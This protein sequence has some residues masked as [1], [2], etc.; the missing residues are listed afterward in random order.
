MFQ[1]HLVDVEQPGVAGTFN[2]H[3]SL[4]ALRSDTLLDRNALP[5]HPSCRSRC[6]IGTVQTH[7]SIRRI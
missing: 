7:R 4:Y 3:F 2:L 1:P 5:N 6:S